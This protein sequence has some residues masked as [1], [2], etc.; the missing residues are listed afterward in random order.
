MMRFIPLQYFRWLCIPLVFLIHLDSFAMETDVDV[1]KTSEEVENRITNKI[2]KNLDMFLSSEQ[3]RLF[4]TAKIRKFREKVILKG[5]MEQ[6]TKGKEAKNLIQSLLPGFQDVE[7]HQQDPKD[8]NRKEKSKFVFKTR[9]RLENLSVRLVLDKALAKELKELAVSSAK[10]VL[11]QAVGKKGNFESVEL[12]LT[13]PKVAETPWQWL[14]SYLKERGATG[15]DLLYV[16]LL[17]VAFLAS[18]LALRHYYKS[19]KKAKDLDLANNKNA[20]SKEDDSDAVCNI[21]LDELIAHLNQSPLIT[22][23]FLKNLNEKDRKTI[24]HS[25]KTPAMQNFFQKILLINELNRLEKV[26]QN[27]KE[28]LE[29]SIKD[30]KRFIELNQ[31]ME[32]KPFGYA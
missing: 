4:T 10:D 3:Y 29:K 15:I 1:M 22:R 28:T 2:S 24:F 32:Q 12:D 18:I 16:F 26:D 6:K 5:E 19:K 8:V 23:I 14:L 11:E 31:E 7:K 13:K 20:V 25:I 21:L 27:A 30:L 9:V 17:L